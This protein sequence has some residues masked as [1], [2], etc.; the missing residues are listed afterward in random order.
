MR[1]AAAPDSAESPSNFAEEGGSVRD[2]GGR[3]EEDDAL[4]RRVSANVYLIPRA[5]VT[6]LQI[7]TSKNVT[8]LWFSFLL[9]NSTIGFADGDALFD[10][11][12]VDFARHRRWAHAGRNSKKISLAFDRPS[13]GGADIFLPVAREV[14]VASG[15]VG[16][17]ALLL[18]SGIGGG[19]ARE[20]E[21][22]EQTARRHRERLFGTASTSAGTILSAPGGVVQE[23]SR[24]VVARDDHEE[25]LSAEDF[26]LP[27]VVQH[28]E[29]A[30]LGR[31]I[32][33]HPRGDMLLIT[34]VSCKTYFAYLREVGASPAVH[35]EALAFLGFNNT[36]LDFGEALGLL[37]TPTETGFPEEVEG[38]E[39]DSPGMAKESPLGW[40][41]HHADS[42]RNFAP[43]ELINLLSKNPDGRDYELWTMLNCVRR[44]L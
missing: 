40:T 12:H 35:P 24:S 16:T 15:V 23:H 11:E 6:R 43:Q 9:P 44:G 34:S 4:V 8:G 18:M 21:R 3:E 2:G 10:R 27:V 7:S 5:L 42:L 37:K 31:N 41:R 29:N 17:P 32:D 20:Q 14:V 33:D 28:V 38:Y 30:E 39:Y 36:K 1:D 13:T 22:Q 26:P 25:E 19:A